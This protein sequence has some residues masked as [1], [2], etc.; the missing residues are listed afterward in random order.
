MKIY[1][2]MASQVLWTKENRIMK[3]EDIQNSPFYEDLVFEISVNA[4]IEP[5]IVAKDNKYKADNLKIQKEEFQ[6]NKENFEKKII[7]LENRLK[8]LVD[9]EKYINYL[10]GA[11][12]EVSAGFPKEKK[13][14]LKNLLSGYARNGMFMQTEVKMVMAKPNNFIKAFLNSSK[15]K[16]ANEKLKEFISYCE[17]NNIYAEFQIDIGG[18]SRDTFDA[19]MS[20]TPIN[21]S[22][23]FAEITA[24]IEKTEQ[25]IQAVKDD[26]SEGENLIKLSDDGYERDN[27]VLIELENEIIRKFAKQMKEQLFPQEIKKEEIVLKTAQPSV[28]VEVKV[29]D[30]SKVNSFLNQL[31][32]PDLTNV[33]D[34]AK[35]SLNSIKNVFKKK[36]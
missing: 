34:K 18:N 35:D 13:Q 33:V 7:R 25:D 4:D 24:Q 27:Y 11:V 10:Y 22:T 15:R 2:F 16:K 32:M 17:T 8:K 29:E 5:L 14:Y 19:I 21:I 1:S 3:I 20:F 30:K 28:K 26:I 36:N 9:T 23:F 6:K 31:K 12:T